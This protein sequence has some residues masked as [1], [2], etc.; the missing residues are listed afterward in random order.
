VPGRRAAAG[1]QG[2]VRARS[3]GGEFICKKADLKLSSVEVE[4]ARGDTIT[5]AGSRVWDI[6]DWEELRDTAEWRIG[7]KEVDS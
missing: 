7:V 6:I 4:T 1:Q 5:D 3:S 2:F